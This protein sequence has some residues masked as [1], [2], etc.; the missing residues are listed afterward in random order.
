MRD[1]LPISCDWEGRTVE[2]IRAEVLRRFPHLTSLHVHVRPHF[3]CAPGDHVVP[4]VAERTIDVPWVAGLRLHEVLD[5]AGALPL[6]G[7]A[8]VWIVR[9]D[10]E[11]FV[12]C[13]VRAFFASADRRHDP[14]LR[15]ADVVVVASKDELDWDRMIALMDGT[16]SPADLARG[17]T[18]VD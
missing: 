8:E 11:V 7:G 17:G 2:A 13:D 10:E 4:V 14:P 12:R 6:P 3:Q 9:R 16:M 1:S 15:P 5:A 18:R